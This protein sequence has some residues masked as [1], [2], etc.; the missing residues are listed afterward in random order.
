MKGAKHGKGIMVFQTTGNRYIQNLCF[1]FY[2]TS[3]LICII[4]PLFNIGTGDTDDGNTTHAA[5][6]KVCWRV[7]QRQD[8][9]HRDV[10]LGKRHNI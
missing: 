7:S 8:A 9:R 4:V 5:D 10:Y 6:V 1:F 2:S 3:L